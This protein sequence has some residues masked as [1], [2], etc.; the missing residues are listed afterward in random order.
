M[1]HNQGMFNQYSSTICCRSI[2]SLLC[3]LAG[4]WLSNS[5]ALAAESS[6]K[7]TANRK[8][9]YLK[10][11]KH[12][13]A[14]KCYACHSTLKQ[15]ADLRL[16][17]KSLMLT[18]GDSGPVLVPGKPAESLILERILAKG[19]EQMPPP[20]AGARLLDRDIALLKKWIE[21][22]AVAPEETIPGSP[23]DHWA[24][25]SPEKSKLPE[26]NRSGWKDHPVDRMLAMLQSQ[27][28]L[29]PVPP[30]S[31][32]ILLRRV[33][34]DLIGLPPTLDEQRAFLNDNSADAYQLVV[35]K[36]LASPQY[37]ER[38]GRHWMDIWRYTDWYGLG[39]QLR[40]S[41]KHIWHWRDWIIES[42]NTDKSYGRMIEEMLAGDELAPTDHDTLRATGFLARN[43]YLFNRT[44]WLDS[45]IEHTSK[46]FLG[47]T[48]NCVKCHDHKYDPLTQNDYY[49]MRAIFEPH[50]VRLDALPGETDFEKNGLP[51]VFDAHLEIPTY[52][53]IRGNT[54]D[55]DKS[56]ELSPGVPEVFAFKEFN[57]SEVSLPAESTNPALQPFVLE[58]HLKMVE[59]EIASAEGALEKAKKLLAQ[60]NDKSK[61]KPLVETTRKSTPFISD[62]FKKSNPEIWELGP[63]KWVYQDGQLIQS[64]IGS[65]RANLR[66]VKNHPSDF[67]AKLKYK[68]TGGQKWKSVGIAFDCI[69]GREKMIYASSVQPGSKVQVSYK[70]GASHVYP[71]NG[72]HACDVELNKPHELEI[73]VRGQLVNVSFNGK[74]VIAYQLPIKRESGRLEL[75]AFD[76][77]VEFQSI[78]V[79]PL[80]LSE[81][82]IEVKENILPTLEVAQLGLEIA[83]K[84]LVIA[85]LH[86]IA[87]KAAYAA[88]V[89]TA[90]KNDVENQVQAAA[91]AAR[92]FELAQAEVRQLTA[93]Q[94]LKSATEKT[95]PTAEKELAAANKA[96][97]QAK[98]ATQKPGAKYTSIRGYRKAFEGP[99]NKED[100]RYT[101]SPSKSTGRRTA[102]A[103]WVANR[104]NPLTARVAV[105]H[106]W[107]RHFGQPLVETVTDFG[108][109][110]DQPIQH[111]L[112]DW[113]AVDFM[114]HNWSM[115]RLHSLIVTSQAYQLGSSTLNADASTMQADPENDYYWRRKPGRMES[116]VVRDSLLHLA[117]TIDFTQGGPNI[118]PST[119]GNRRT[120]YFTVNRDK[121]NKFASM[122]DPAD[123]L[124]CYR[125]DASVIPQQAL[126]LAN[127][128]LALG[129]S[130]EITAKLQTDFPKMNDEQFIQTAFELILSID[131]TSDELALCLES[132]KE[133]TV[134][135]ANH[136]KINS[137]QRARE[138]LVHALINHNDFITI[139]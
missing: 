34:L 132:L 121:Q 68:T 125:R 123:I 71:T 7:S 53:H 93:T 110:T 21:E 81:K 48:M 55:P 2:L 127:S 101:A 75:I 102:F 78:D 70:T 134:A 39:A 86:S 38:W 130:R 88:D 95:K 100:F 14:E 129:K 94:K 105:N 24:F 10:Q 30:A 31:K 1:V 133:T 23:R 85:N 43:Y 6:G 89:A 87:I 98:Q 36:L 64:Q 99:A 104:K 122:F 84:N 44:T 57:V 119:N 66:S 35:Q 46:A 107:L 109:R 51:R 79:S 45:T 92:K 67:K 126:T 118:E 62:S 65:Q 8:I 54:K 27:K 137:E 49:R 61:S 103:R 19:D 18:G 29:K 37:G 47:L 28:N 112:L 82:L 74:H 13:L 42:L 124:N 59:Q 56:Q 131:P 50:Q 108:L 16:E 17:T 114:E 11:V 4:A 32:R 106:I 135:L 58:A 20:E 15:E 33:Y 96:L 60:A 5:S 111:Q 83:E 138:N 139:R 90:R 69:E 3:C 120:L 41:Q 80:A 91:I 116:E 113:L 115:K 9:D 26:I 52:L 25:Q 22:G 117:G 12:I 77:A 72:L 73:A 63:G 76:A 128:K 40:N 136:A 97:E